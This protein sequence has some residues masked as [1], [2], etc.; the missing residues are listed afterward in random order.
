MFGLSQ[1]GL[2]KYMDF[3]QMEIHLRGSTISSSR[4]F[5]GYN[6]FETL[7]LRMLPVSFSFTSKSPQE[8]YVLMLECFYPNQRENCY[9]SN[10]KVYKIYVIY[11]GNAVYNLYYF[12]GNLYI[13][14]VNKSR[15]ILSDGAGNKNSF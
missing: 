4:N 15:G 11:Y 10:R 5:I 12:W 3:R 13:T 1:S 8:P 9:W 6:T 14:S 2:C 7:Y